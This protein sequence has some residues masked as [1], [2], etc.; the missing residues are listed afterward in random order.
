MGAA[1]VCSTPGSIASKEIANPKNQAV[2]GGFG[3]VLFMPN[4]CFQQ[5]FLIHPSFILSSCLNHFLI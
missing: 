1:A 3:Q 5:I 4:V 2:T